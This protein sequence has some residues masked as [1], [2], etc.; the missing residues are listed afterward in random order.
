MMAAAPRS[1]IPLGDGF[2][3]SSI[4][5]LWLGLRVQWLCPKTLL[6][7]GHGA[8]ACNNLDV[9]EF[10]RF[11]APG[12]QGGILNWPPAA[13]IPENYLRPFGR[14]QPVIPPLLQSQIS[15]E[16]IAPFLGQYVFVAA[17][18]FGEPHARHHTEIDEL[19][20]PCAENVRRNA[21][22]VLKFVEPPSA[23]IGF[24]KE[25]DR[26]AVADHLHGPGDGTFL[27]E[28]TLQIDRKST[29]L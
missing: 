11:A 24:P 2:P 1:H 3:N 8:G 12:H 21:E 27:I 7:E 22:I 16:K 18:M 23:I 20:Q 17:A 15:R 29:R 10:Q 25:Q 26:P 13:A 19:L 4:A 5:T 28:R 6:V 9:L 14:C